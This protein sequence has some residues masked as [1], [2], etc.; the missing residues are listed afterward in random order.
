MIIEAI[1]EVVAP[2]I[3]AMKK[4]MAEIEE[5]MK[6]HMSKPASETVSE[7]RFNKANKANKPE[8]LNKKRYEMALNRINNK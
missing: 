6:E 4:K 7:K 5:V 3:D 8:V 2:E 1:A